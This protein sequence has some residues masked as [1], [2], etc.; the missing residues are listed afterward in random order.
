MENL[1]K[2][3]CAILL[4]VN[5]FA[6]NSN[7]NSE[8]RP[9]IQIDKKSSV[10]QSDISE[11]LDSLNSENQAF[12]I[13]LAKTTLVTGKY[14]TKVSIPANS[15][16]NSKKQKVKGKAILYLKENYTIE[17]FVGDKLSTI[18]DDQRILETGGMINIKVKQG[19]DVLLMKSHATYKVYIPNKEKNL[20]PDYKAFYQSV[21]KD[22]IVEWKEAKVQSPDLKPI[23][24]IIEFDKAKRK[25]KK[26]YASYFEKRYFSEVLEDEKNRYWRI[27]SNCTELNEKLFNL[28]NDIDKI[29]YLYNSNDSLLQFKIKLGVDNLGKIQTCNVTTFEHLPLLSNYFKHIV[30]NKITNLNYKKISSISRLDSTEWFKHRMYF[31]WTQ[32][33]F[34]VNSK[35]LLNEF[36]AKIKDF[37]EIENSTNNIT[38]YSANEYIMNL[39]G[40]G[41]INLDRYINNKD[42][43]VDLQLVTNEEN[44]RIILLFKNVNSLIQSQTDHDSF[45]LIKGVPKD[46]DVRIIVLK[47]KNG[48]PY[49]AVKNSIIGNDG[50][51]MPALTATTLAKIKE[52]LKN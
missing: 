21:N 16:V 29:M 1:S 18:T 48:T 7:K 46:A 30:S 25:I 22:G 4:V 40:F 11:V 47:V 15:L 27:S 36:R 44:C 50:I 2:I 12:E 19:N 52:E 20:K 10:I 13:E 24:L 42:G 38:E 37:S 3:T 49:Y 26:Q 51:T 9:K 43:N 33:D 32:N 45:K 6:C 28:F 8:T 41:W 39:N 23:N 14:G 34:N 35:K 31:K 5:L 17:N